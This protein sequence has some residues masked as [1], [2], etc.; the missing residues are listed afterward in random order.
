[1]EGGRVSPFLVGRVKPGAI[2]RLGGVE[3]TFVLPDPVPERILFISAGSGIT[4]IIG[5]L[6]RLG[7]TGELRDVLH[8]HCA[9]RA[10]SVIFARELAEL[11]LRHP[12]YRLERW[13]TGERGRLR[14]GQLDGLSAKTGPSARRSSAV[15]LACSRR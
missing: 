14:P 15:L 8:I 2:V 9:R 11:R 5:M 10:E 13:L 4:P 1:M 3:G 6:R 12:G 7:A